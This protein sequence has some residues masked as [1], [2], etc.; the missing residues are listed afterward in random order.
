AA[1]RPTMPAAPSPARPSNCTQSCCMRARRASPQPVPSPLPSPPPPPT[2]PA[3]PK[4]TPAHWRP[5]AATSPPGP[6]KPAKPTQTSSPGRSSYRPGFAACAHSRDNPCIT[7]RAARMNPQ[8]DPNA[9][10]EVREPERDVME[11]DVVTVG[12]GPAGLAFAIR[13]KQVNPDISVCVIEKSST[14]GAHI[15]SGAVIEPG[16][17][18]ALLPGWR[19]NPPPVC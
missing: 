10:V 1:S 15:L 11:Y 17:L 4:P 6:W 9:T 19:D 8:A 14:I 16:P 3:W 18:D 7:T 5:W 12:A 13:L 2:W